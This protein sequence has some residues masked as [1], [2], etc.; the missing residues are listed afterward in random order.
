MKLSRYIF[1]IFLLMAFI[2]TA[3]EDELPYVSPEIGEG[4]ATINAEVE[5]R[6]LEPALESRAAG[7]AVDKINELWVVIYNV[8]AD[9]SDAG[10]YDKVRLYRASDDYT[11]PYSDFQIDQTGN[12]TYPGPTSSPSGADNVGPDDGEISGSGQKTPHA[13]FKLNNIPYGRYKIFAVANVDLTD[14]DCST[15][16]AL[17]S[18]RFEWDT[19][20]TK[21]NQMFGYFTES[22]LQTSRAE[23]PVLTLNQPAMS[24][25][26]WIRRLVSKVTVSF[27]PSGLKEA[28]RI[29]IKSVTIR[30][31][32]LSCA[33]GEKNSPDASDEIITYGDSLTYYNP[34]QYADKFFKDWKIVLSKGSGPQGETGHTESDPALYF[35]ENMQGNYENNPAYDKRQ[36]TAGDDKVG[37]SIIKPDRD[38]KG[39]IKNDFKDRVEYGT[40]IE[41]K[42]YYDSFNKDKISSGPITY[43]FM[44]GK[45][46]T[47]N[48]DAER[49]YHY[50]LTLKFRGWAN[51]ADWH[52][53]Y[54]EY[55][56]TLLTPEPYYIS[57]LYGQKMDFPAR[58]ILPPTED[59]SQY[60]VKAEIVENNWWPWD[61]DVENPDGTKGA[62][63]AQFVPDGADH[64]LK[65][66]N[67]FAWNEPAMTVYPY[68]KYTPEDYKK[69]PDFIYNGS[70]YVGFL[71]LQEIKETSIPTSVSG[72]G[73]AANNFLK[74]YYKA[75]SIPIKEY[76]LND[77]KYTTYDDIDKS[78]SLKIPMYTREKQM[79]NATDFTGNNPFN[80]FYRFARVRFTLWKNGVQIPYT[81]ADGKEETERLATIYQVPRIENPKVIYRDWYN[82]DAFDIKL[83]LPSVLDANGQITYRPFKSDGPWRASILCETEQFIQITGK[84]GKTKTAV[85]DYINGSTD[86]IIEFTYKPS[87]KLTSSNLTRCGIIKVEYNDYNC[88]H[89]IFV[90]Q[91]YHAGVKLGTATWSCYNV[92]SSRGAST[93]L[94][95][96][97]TEGNVAQ[98]Q[99]VLTKN[100]LSI[101]SF[102]KRNQY[103]YGI[104]ESNNNTYPWMTNIGTL[105]TTHVGSDNKLAATRAATWANIRGAAWNRRTQAW[106]TEWNAV[107][108]VYEN[109]VK[110]A[111][112]TAAH[113]ISLMNNCQYGYGIAYADGSTST[114]ETLDAAGGFID[115]NNDGKDDNPVVSGT[116]S[117]ARGVRVCVVYDDSDGKNILFPVGAT[118]QGRRAQSAPYIGPAN[119]NN[120]PFWVPMS[121]WANWVDATKTALT[122]TLK[123]GTLAYGGMANVLAGDGNR[124]RPL[125]YNLL[126]QSGALYWINVPNFINNTRNDSYGAWDINYNTVRFNPHDY[127]SLGGNT[128]TSLTAA[129]DITD[130]MPIKLIYK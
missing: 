40:Y 108:G 90:R 21:D 18:T 89:L 53:N 63:P 118:G 29:Y 47:F 13:T 12:S 59:R 34:G 16:D 111:V 81:N 73:T 87:G 109:G 38:D 49:N 3:C 124:Y 112:P 54:K 107:D 72:Y 46:S 28:V 11:L 57:Y 91:G 20:V 7:N 50:K 88:I 9:G 78:I 65:L 98:A 117:S 96:Y 55:T 37:E 79:V 114:A 61:R 6:S 67:G 115:S 68:Q 25:H 93:N 103:N 66:I 80:N 116:T 83:L 126:R 101:G 8:K 27:D 56:P 62:R 39:N 22:S 35:F 36:Q 26:S 19:D 31:I 121:P 105:T 119:E 70:N 113:F 1:P 33:L 104:L 41:V 48:Y 17:R 32:P 75:S 74:D 122:N 110:F 58:V 82:D 127:G 69:D 86:E 99:V 60:V 14:V 123:A 10:L 42:A 2:F 97:E 24:F 44:L 85:G 77:A 125:T 84:D 51:E 52:I 43:R 76:R 45:N 15:V 120:G 129:N 94:N 100:P 23:A 95:S 30:D 64:G 71:S 130:A 106:A 128:G 102:Y 92:Y 4:E 5:F